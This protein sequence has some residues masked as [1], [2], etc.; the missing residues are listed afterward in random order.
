MSAARGDSG[1]DASHRK[2]QAWM[3][4]REKTAREGTPEPKNE[5]SNHCGKLQAN[6]E[7]SPFVSR[8]PDTDHSTR[9]QRR[10]AKQHRGA[11]GSDSAQR[12]EAQQSQF[13]KE[14]IEIPILAQR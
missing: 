12:S 2:V 10:Q 1:A 14:I 5:N 7:Q 9:W 8:S 4:S 3:D 13:I 11:D 6:N